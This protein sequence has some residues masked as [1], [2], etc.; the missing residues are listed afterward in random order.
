MKKIPFTGETKDA[1][2]K[3]QKA[4]GLFLIEEQH[5]FDGQFLVFD[6]KP[7]SNE[8]PETIASLTAKVKALDEKVKVLEA[9]K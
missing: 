8:V 5:H 4:M 3:E 6:T 7:Q 9:K 1:I 2:A